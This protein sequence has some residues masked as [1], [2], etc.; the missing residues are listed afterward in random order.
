MWN[1]SVRI[2]HL[3]N[4]LLTIIHSH[5]ECFVEHAVGVLLDRKTMR[6]AD[7]IRRSICESI[8]VEFDLSLSKILRFIN[9]KAATC[10]LKEFMIQIP[11]YTDE[12]YVYK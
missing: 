6:G 7:C 4:N 12:Y 1:A 10:E 3:G 9:D 8:H 5:E 11:I 2:R